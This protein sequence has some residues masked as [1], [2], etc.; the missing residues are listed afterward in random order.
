MATPVKDKYFLRGL[1]EEIGLFD[2]KLAHL[3]KYENFASDK[4]R[5]AAAGKLT[6][7]R[8]QLVRAA[9]QMANEGVE[10]K[11]SE[12][13]RSLRPEDAEAEP[14]EVKAPVVAEAVA[15]VLPDL[16]KRSTPAG[17][18]GG[19]FDFGHEIKAYIEKRKKT[20]VLTP[21]A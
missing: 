3:L 21:E 16:P 17:Q 15:P 1:H 6:A 20:L 4:E 2:R 12:L 9:K 13:P 7:K 18:G 19:V 5:D 11:N 8:E 14:E 10:F